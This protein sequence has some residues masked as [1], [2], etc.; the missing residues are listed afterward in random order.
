[1]FQHMRLSI[2]NGCTPHS[3]IL[4][5]MHSHILSGIINL[6]E[7]LKIVSDRSEHL[8]SFWANMRIPVAS[9]LNP[10]LLSRFLGYSSPWLSNFWPPFHRSILLFTLLSI[11]A[12]LLAFRANDGLPFKYNPLLLYYSFF[13]FKMNVLRYL[14]Q[15]WHF[16][17]HSHI[18]HHVLLNCIF[19]C[20]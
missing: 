8:P 10:F 2:R 18:I 17:R 14:F 6:L 16:Y 13:I 15:D 7:N 9:N 5:P 20:H 12:I 3:Y 11:M 1:M 19:V 4:I